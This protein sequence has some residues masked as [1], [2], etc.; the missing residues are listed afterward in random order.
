[1]YAVQNNNFE[2]TKLLLEKGANVNFKDV[3]GYFFMLG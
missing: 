3:V 1:M 2:I